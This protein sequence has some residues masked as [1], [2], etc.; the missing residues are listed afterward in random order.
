RH[1]N[2]FGEISFWAGLFLFALAADPGYWWTGIGC[3]A[4]WVMFQF[5]TLPMMEKRNLARRPDYAEV[6]KRVPRLFP[7]FPKS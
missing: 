3:F 6:M 1:P 4:M 2:Y 5:G 7:W